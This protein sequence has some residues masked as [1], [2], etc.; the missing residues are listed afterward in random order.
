MPM[1]LE[2]C[3]LLSIGFGVGV[4]LMIMIM[5][6]NP[7]RTINYKKGQIDALTGHV[8]YELI[9]DKKNILMWRYKNG[10]N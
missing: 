8:R 4:V 6:F 9:V 5:I 3:Y 1:W 10:D 7:Y 2:R